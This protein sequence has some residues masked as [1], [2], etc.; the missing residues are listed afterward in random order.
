MDSKISLKVRTRKITMGI[1]LTLGVF[2][3]VTNNNHLLDVWA[4]A[5]K[6]L[7]EIMHYIYILYT[8]FILD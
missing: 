1:N 3:P 2:R 6:K 7:I 4:V 8:L 5:R